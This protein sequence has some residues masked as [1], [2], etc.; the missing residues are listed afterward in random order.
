MTP[1]RAVWRRAVALA[2]GL[3]LP[4]GCASLGP[5]VPVSVATADGSA[6]YEGERTRGRASDSVALSTQDGADCA[7][8]LRQTKETATGRPAA[9]GAIHCAD[10]ASGILLFSGGPEATGGAVSGVMARRP[11]RGG[12][13]DGPGAGA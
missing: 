4:A 10:G 1:G 3:M 6:R 5:G 11:V 2:A 7:G 12:W 13:G 9:F 8:D